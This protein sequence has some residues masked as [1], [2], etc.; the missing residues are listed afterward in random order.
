[1]N[2][3]DRDVDALFIWVITGDAELPSECFPET[4]MLPELGVIQLAFCVPPDSRGHIF[5]VSGEMALWTE[6]DE[7]AELMAAPLAD[8]NDM[9]YFKR[10]I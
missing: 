5:T 2:I 3:G 1:M 8:W 10:D 4:E 7:I 6:G 9:M